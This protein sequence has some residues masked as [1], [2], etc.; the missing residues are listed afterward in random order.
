MYLPGRRDETDASDKA[1]DGKM[2][3]RKDPRC[4]SRAGTGGQR[5]SCSEKI[6]DGEPLWDVPVFQDR[7]RLQ[8]PVCS[9]NEKQ[10]YF[11]LIL[12]VSSLTACTPMW[13]D[14]S[15]NHSLMA[16]HSVS[17]GF[18]FRVRKRG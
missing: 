5:Y 12:F 15:Y 4:H 18:G 2:P 7:N 1:G 9:G 8:S 11:W 3:T 16:G 10:I 17:R 13:A 14:H 6:Q